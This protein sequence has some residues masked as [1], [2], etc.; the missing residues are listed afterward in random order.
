[1][2]ER[3][4]GVTD[5]GGVERHEG[6]LGSRVSQAG[7]LRSARIES[8]RAL[9]ALG[10]MLGHTFGSAHDYEPTQTLGAGY[11][12]RAI[13]GG[14]FGVFLFFALSGYLLYWPF[15]KR[16]LAG[17]DAI[18]LRRYALNR[19]VRILPLY[20]AVV[21]V[22]LLLQPGGGTLGQWWR[23]LLFAENFSTDTVAKVDG[24]VWSLVVEL[25]FYLLLP[26]LALAISWIAR[27]SR[28][29]AALVLVAL[30]GASYLLGRAT[31]DSGR[32]WRYSLPTT[33]WFFIAGML[34][35]V[36]R[37]HWQERRPWWLRGP[38]ASSDVWLLAAV[39]LWLLVFWHYRR[40][41]VPFASA[42]MVGACV[43][44]LRPGYGVRL[45][46]WRPLAAIGVASYSL[47]LWHVLILQRLTAN[48]VLPNAGFPL[49][50]AIA[51]PI[52]I[53]VAIASYR[54]I[55]APF[56]RL[57][58]RWSASAPPQTEPVGLAQSL[59]PAPQA[60]TPS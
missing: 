59:E 42:L 3:G 6:T 29:R 25:H 44:P 37:I 50:L 48:S 5:A 55:E 32:L 60:G 4:E 56:L 51:A 27:R 34:L 28:G 49:L 26:F 53:G 38:I 22:A 24:V 11:L 39:G 45:L 33:F 20:Y 10:V 13:F 14:G 7:E 43:L 35:A 19:A 18:D 58:R 12:H 31:V 30:G 9:A 1:M 46:E 47:Y 40:E 16:D 36:V 15:A 57:R 21:V 52:C 2:N 17:G 41:P 8:L 23:F 54:V